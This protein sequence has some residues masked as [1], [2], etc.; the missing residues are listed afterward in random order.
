[1]QTVISTVVFLLLLLGG[2]G[3]VFY[4]QQTFDLIDEVISPNRASVFDLERLERDGDRVL[5]WRRERVDTSLAECRT[6]ALAL[7][8]AMTPSPMVRCV[9]YTKDMK[10]LRIIVIE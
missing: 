5:G 3:F 6:H 1:M 2:I 9:A 8:A 4:P 7:K 10:Q